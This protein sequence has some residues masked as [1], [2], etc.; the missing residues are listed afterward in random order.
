M[1]PETLRCAALIG[2]FSLVPT[3]GAAQTQPGLMCQS[4]ADVAVTVMENRQQAVPEQAMLE[5]VSRGEGT[6]NVFR[7]LVA[8]AYAQP[9]EPD[10]EGRRAV[11]RAFRA[12]IEASCLK[13]VRGIA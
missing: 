6:D 10:A 7:A 12:T 8:E 1:M 5:L 9:I 11:I 13:A 3:L 2:A 4:I